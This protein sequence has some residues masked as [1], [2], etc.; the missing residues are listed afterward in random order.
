MPAKPALRQEALLIAQTRYEAYLGAE[1]Y[2][3]DVPGSASA[4][5]PG[6][7]PS[8]RSCPARCDVSTVRIKYAEPG[9]NPTQLG[10]T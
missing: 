3:M 1:I 6:V 7:T 5:R 9:Y 10:N 8:S 2:F 4:R